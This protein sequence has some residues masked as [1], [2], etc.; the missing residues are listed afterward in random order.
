MTVAVAATLTALFSVSSASAVTLKGLWA[1]INRCPVDD[2]SMLASSYTPETEVRSYCLTA[3]SRKGSLKL[4]GLAL[5]TGPVDSQMGVLADSRFTWPAVLPASGEGIVTPAQTVSG[6]LTGLVCGSHSDL[7]SDLCT[8]KTRPERLERVTSKVESAGAPSNFSLI[9]TLSMM[10]PIIDL[11]VKVHLQNPIL[12][13]NCYIG[14]N[15]HPIV[16]RPGNV[17]ENAPGLLTF[18]AEGVVDITGVMFEGYTPHTAQ[19]DS[20]FA[21]GT[22]TGCGPKGRFND[23]INRTVGLPS[24]AGANTMV[25]KDMSTYIIGLAN[26]TPTDGADLSQLWHEAVIG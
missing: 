9:A 6:G 8:S 20:S 5:T 13:P 21:V 17:M 26:P 12:G 23:A 18:N 11:P 25:W 3:T 10:V 1:P 24:P 14:S 15:A 2:P 7:K 4:G 19:G 22:A 16:L